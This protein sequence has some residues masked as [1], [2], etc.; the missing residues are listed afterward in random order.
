[1]RIA[2][3]ARS[4]L[5][6][7]P[8]GDT[9][10]VLETAAGLAR[11]GVQADVYLTDKPIVYHH[12]DLLHFFNIIRPADILRHVGRTNKPYV[13]STIFVEYGHEVA[14]G[15]LRHTIKVVLGADGAEYVKAIGRYVKNGERID[16]M[17]YLLKGHRRAVKRVAA[18]AALLL[19]NSESE[20][21]RF[22]ITYGIKRPYIVVPN[23]VHTEHI[24]ATYP[25]L[26]AYEGAVICMARIEPLKNQLRL[27]HALRGSGYKLFIHG[28]PAPNHIGYYN[29]CVHAAGEDCHIAGWLD[30]DALY[31]AYSS[32]KVHVLPSFF[33]TTGLSSL[34]A[35]AMGCNIVVG[36]GGD[37]RDYF[38][39]RAWYCSPTD[40][41]SIRAAVDAAY[42]APYDASFREYILSHYTW[43][44]AAA[45]TLRAYK[46]VL[47]TN[48][49]NSF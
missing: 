44:R 29:H 36:T 3:I 22:I 9:K 27:I 23:G 39:N 43:D 19:P 46:H 26:P 42:H 35:A 4:T 40:T 5:H 37:T 47:G 8:G 21:R 45:E 13:V 12:Y 32:A 2:L 6:S 28:K 34:E 14:P 38:G 16:S 10:Q 20:Y 48:L 24:S 31:A 7:S 17:S 41:A 49:I 25:K 30:T 15:S 33:E 11:L 1:M 18:G